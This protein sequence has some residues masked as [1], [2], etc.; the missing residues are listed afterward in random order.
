MD[1]RSRRPIQLSFLDFVEQRF[2]ADAQD[3]GGLAPV[4]PRLLQRA[5]NQLALGF[6]RGG[7]AR[8]PSA[9]PLD[10]RRPS[11]RTRRPAPVTQPRASRDGGV[12]CAPLQR[13]ERRDRARCATRV[14]RW[15]QPPHGGSAASVPR[16][17]MRLT[18]FSS[19]RTFP[20]H[21]Y[22]REEPERVGRERGR[23]PVVVLRVLLEELIGQR[24]NLVAALTQR[25]QRDADDV[26]TEEEV[27][28]ELARLRPPIP[29]HD[30]WRP[31]RGRRRA[32]PAVHRAARTRRPGAPGGASPAAARS[33][34]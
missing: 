16:I 19:S 1:R 14:P 32:R 4:P 15:R 18:R 26:Q 2:V 31:P 33:S 23:R 27:L 17:T 29:G 13:L 7:A 22:S 25:R 34:R 12:G 20:G 21:S 5:G 10:P 28:T 11:A 6:A 9:I 24:R 3:F 8:C 30:W